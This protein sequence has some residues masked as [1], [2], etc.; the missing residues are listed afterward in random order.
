MAGFLPCG[1]GFR[2]SMHDE[3]AY[4]ADQAHGLPPITV[5][6]RIEAADGKRVIENKL[7]RLE[8]QPVIALV[9]SVFLIPPRPPHAVPIIRVATEL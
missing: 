6:V 9:G 8:A 7:R 4:R 1:I 3:Q 5:R 2:P